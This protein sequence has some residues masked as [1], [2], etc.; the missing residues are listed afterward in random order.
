MALSL[1]SSPSTP[2]DLASATPLA[3]PASTDPTSNVVRL[4][5][6]GIAS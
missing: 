1:A 4:A 5:S 2:R 6:G 3:A